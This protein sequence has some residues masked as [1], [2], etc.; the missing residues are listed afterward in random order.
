MPDVA[1]RLSLN[2]ALDAPHLAECFAAHG[3]LQISDFLTHDSARALRDELAGSDAWRHL[4]SG[5]DQVFEIARGDYDAMAAEERQRIEKAVFEA[6]AQRFQFQYDAIR[7]PDSPAERKKRS[8]RL[9]EFACLMSAP[10]TREILQQITG[11]DD[12]AF[13]D[14]QATCYRPGDFL[15]RHD[16]DVAGKNRRLAYV[17]GLTDG[18]QAEWGG[19]LQF[20]DDRGGIA[21]TLV[22]HFN[23]LSL[24][25]VPQPHSVS[26]VVPFARAHRVSITGWIRSA[27]PA[28]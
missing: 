25:A 20:N 27:A 24:F 13:A 16:D 2:S 5:A 4:I 17:L 1:S 9:V 8:T 26:Y 18:W 21:E 3:R 7:V 19:L 12:L 11:A 23:T 6:A 22:P 15:L 28:A 14:A 10:G